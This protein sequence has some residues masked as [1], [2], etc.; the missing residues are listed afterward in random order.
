MRFDSALVGTVLG[1]FE[2]EVDSGWTMSYAAGIG[3][4]SPVYLDSL[5]AGGLFAHPVFPVCFIWKGM[6]Q[7]DR[8]LRDS[9]LKHDEFV[10]RVH[11]SHAMILHSPVRPSTRV[12]SR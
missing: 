1:P 9:A 5:R 8:K 4:M 7:L 6:A 10:R 12:T 11:A 2:D 3:D